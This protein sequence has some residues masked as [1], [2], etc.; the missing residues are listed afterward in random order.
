MS[1]KQ[2]RQQ[3]T[4]HMK[5]KYDELTAITPLDGRYRN[6]CSELSMYVSEYSLIKMRIEIEAKYLLALAKI[7]LIRP[8][9][10]KERTKLDLFSN[11]ITLEIAKNV[12]EIETKTRHDVKAMERTFRMLLKDTSLEDI[13]EMIHF[14][15]TS[16]DVNNLA[17]RS[18]LYKTTHAVCLPILEQII[19]QLTEK[20]NVYKTIPMLARTH[21]QAAVPT[22]VGKELV[23]FAKR[24]HTQ[25]LVLKKQKLTGKLTG[26]VGNFNALYLAYPN[27]NWLTFSET[28]VSSLEF[29]PNLIT[30]QINAYDD[31]SEYF[32]IYQRINN[33]LIDFDQDMWRYISDNWYIQEVKTGEVGSSTMPQKVNPIDFENSE[34]NLGMANAILQFLSS[35][36]MISRLQRDLSDSTV[37]RN[38][39]T[40]LGFC[41]IGYKSVLS[42]LARVKP[43]VAQ[44]DKD[45]QKDWAILTEGVQTILRKANVSD[46]YSL[47]ASLSR[48]HHIE[49]KEWINWITELPVDEV[50][51]NILKKLTPQNYIGLAIR[52]TEKAIQEIKSKK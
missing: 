43:N 46:P 40:V 34:G 36:L 27:I 45:L 33:I 52:L 23:V 20:A 29:I 31:V 21:G 6:R 24:L 47:I 1:R 3:K 9:S 50:N 7:K 30:T 25:V 26:A 8:L 2:N 19:N 10:V 22:T 39:G 17:Y 49:K 16:E 48:G 4:V 51:K 28:F 32:Q 11:T 18:L 35:K 15:L 44:I 37:I 5:I 42:G 38:I 12:K 41:L 14:G 13:T